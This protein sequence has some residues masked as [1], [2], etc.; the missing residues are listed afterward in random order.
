VE[1]LS[2][3]SS[4]FCV[5]MYPKGSVVFVQN[6]VAFPKV[7]VSLSLSAYPVR[8]RYRDMSLSSQSIVKLCPSLSTSIKSCPEQSS[9][10]PLYG[11]SVAF[12]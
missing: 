9:S 7:H 8:L 10:I 1:S 2:F 6:V 12:G 4:L 11:I 5:V 3:M